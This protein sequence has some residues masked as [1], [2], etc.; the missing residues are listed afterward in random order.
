M[1]NYTQKAIVQTFEDMLRE[2]PFDKITVSA[3]VARCEI[4]SNT[5]YYHFRDIYDLLESWLDI[6][7]SKY[8]RDKGLMEHWNDT[9]KVILHD[10]QNNKELVNHV[11][12]SISRDRLERYVFN[13]LEATIY[14]L[15]QE[16]AEG[17]PV[18][19]ELQ[20]MIASSCC[21]TLLGFLIKFIW[22]DMK[23]DVEESVD[24]LDKVFDGVVE[25]VIKKNSDQ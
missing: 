3:I 13:T 10:V 12:D 4:S 19:E 23:A 8:L 18:T 17:T 1:A 5:F 20:Q 24:R 7:Q 6:K 21:Y 11:F 9:L 22:N 14:H 15:V 25:Y 16:K 2:M